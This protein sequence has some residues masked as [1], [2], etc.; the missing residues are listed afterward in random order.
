ML[1]TAVLVYRIMYHHLYLHLF[2]G[3]LQHA[4]A[5]AGAQARVLVL[6]F[7]ARGRR[8]NMASLDPAEKI[9]SCLW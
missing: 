1:A 9:V 3:R 8:T 4:G 5:R 2:I 7:R 6:Q